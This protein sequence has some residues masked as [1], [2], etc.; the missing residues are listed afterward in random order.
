MLVGASQ[1]F[2]R[3]GTITFNVATS[4]S[5]THELVVIKT[6]KADGT[7][8][9]DPSSAGQVDETGSQGEA[10]DVAGG[11]TATLTLNS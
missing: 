2:A 9:V 7:I 3:A 8:P 4:G 10:D 6:D 1:T 11:T 5:I